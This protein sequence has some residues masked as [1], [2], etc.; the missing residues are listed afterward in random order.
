M[1]LRSRT[2]L[3]RYGKPVRRSLVERVQAAEP[4]EK[5][6]WSP[7]SHI[8]QNLCMLSKESRNGRTY[9]DKALDALVELYEGARAY[10][11]HPDDA[12][13]PR[14][15]KERIGRWRNVRKVDGKIR[16]DLHYDP[17]HPY[18][19]SLIWAAQECPEHCGI[20]HN[21]EAEGYEDPETGHF[22]VTRP[23]EVRS[24][25]VV[26]DAATNKSL[27]ESTKPRR[28][29]AGVKGS[30][31][32]RRRKVK[33]GAMD[34]ELEDDG[35]GMEGETP[36]H[37]LG[38]YIS[39]CCDD[40]NMDKAS[41]RKKILKA[42]DLYDEPE[43]DMEKDEQ[44]DVE[45]DPEDERESPR[46]QEPEDDD[47]FLEDDE[48][49]DEEPAKK[50]SP[51]MAKESHQ[52]RES[53]KRLRRHKDKNIR[54]VAEI[55]LRALPKP[56][57]RKP[58][59]QAATESLGRHADPAV[60]AMAKR[61]D[62]LEAEKIATTSVKAAIAECHAAGLPKRVMTRLFI[63]DLAECTDK[64]RRK[65]MIQE[66]AHLA[67]ISLP[68]SFGPGGVGGGPPRISNEDFA[69]MVAGDGE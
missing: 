4:G 27:L 56:P 44:D 60:R 24:V 48:D 39:A 63:E 7:E 36:E 28:R 35:M 62:I 20:S 61:L 22:T 32:T 13:A 31:L 58:V 52:A 42:L 19:R 6:A 29:R 38:A 12:T 59:H 10:Q 46:G 33:E 16:G 26:D 25:D 66:R 30:H 51:M 69:A 11:D 50:E 49:E 65:A 1:R 64:R 53:L 54:A 68:R 37:H 43:A 55:A 41:K 21:I 14:S 2:L 34:P 17:N 23:T 57:A 3:E 40:P 9:T 47:Q 5:I 8:L 15:T 67:S 18:S 45:T